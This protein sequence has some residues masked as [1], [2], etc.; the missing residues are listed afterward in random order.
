MVTHGVLE[1]V[2]PAEGT[3]LS[4]LQVDTF[5]VLPDVV[6]PLAHI[7]A[8]GTRPKSGSSVPNHVFKCLGV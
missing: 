5:N 7:G 1:P 3:G 2:L 6:L 8:D 4:L